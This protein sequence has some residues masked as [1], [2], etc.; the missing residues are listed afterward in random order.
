MLPRGRAR[1]R[2]ARRADLE[3]DLQAH[4]PARAAQGLQ[5]RAP[6]LA[7]TSSS[8]AA[9]RS[10]CARTARSSSTPTATRSATTPATV[11]VEHRC[12]RVDRPGLMY[13]PARAARPARAGGQ[14]RAL[15]R[16]RRHDRARA[17]AAAPRPGRAAQHG[18]RARR[19]L[20]ARLRHERQDDDVGDARRL[21][22][23]RPGDPSSTTAPAR[24][25]RW[26]VA[27]ALLDAGRGRG[28]LG[29][30]EVDEAWLPSVAEQL[31]P[32]LLLLSNLFRDQLDRY[33]EL[34]LLADRWAEL[35]DAP[36]RGRPR[37]VLNADDPLVADLGPRP[38]AASPTSASRTTRRRCPSMQHAADSKHCRNCGARLRLRG[39][40]PRPPGPL[41]LPELRARAAR[42]RRW[43][44]TQRGS[45][46]A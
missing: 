34:E 23:A 22:R 12:L 25:W 40:L 17:R 33:G 9:R 11:R 4:L 45:S 39:D 21:P 5:G 35:V 10:R 1:R 28:Q 20:A 27:T 43:R 3:G 8:C 18:E 44:P 41:P 31:E 19:G 6:R 38:R 15:G 30:F 24:T 42:R 46:T 14:P 7:A 16:T 26:G 37:F 13:R 36:G 29:L 2:P 32:R